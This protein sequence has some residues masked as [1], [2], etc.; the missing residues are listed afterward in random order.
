MTR[1]VDDLETFKVRE[2][3]K[4]IIPSLRLFAVGT[5]EFVDLMSKDRGDLVSS[6]HCTHLINKR[7]FEVF[8]DKVESRCASLN[9]E[10]IDAVVL[11]ITVDRKAR[12]N[13]FYWIKCTPDEERGIGL[14]RLLTL[15]ACMKQGRSIEQARLLAEQTPFHRSLEGAGLLAT[16][17]I[18]V[19]SKLEDKLENKAGLSLLQNQEGFA[20]MSTTR[21]KKEETEGPIRYTHTERIFGGRLSKEDHKNPL[22]S[23]LSKLVQ[24]YKS[25]GFTDDDENSEPGHADLK[26]DFKSSDHE[27]V[28]SL[29]MLR[30]KRK[31]D[32]IEKR[33]DELQGTQDQGFSLPQH[34]GDQ[35]IQ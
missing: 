22:E 4:A 35:P 5:R 25:A 2:S 23:R 32:A 11:E 15:A 13:K 17:L 27:Q 20:E 28:S 30:T 19:S 6:M 24:T 8:Q 10:Q 21:S 14:E 1:I 3:N 33:M 7:S 12:L 26:Y 16:L 31:L 29:K 18:T 34:T 9:E